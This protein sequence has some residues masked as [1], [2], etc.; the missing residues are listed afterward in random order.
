MP[1]I[2]FRVDVATHI[3]TGHWQRCL[4]LARYLKSQ[5]CSITFFYRKYGEGFEALYNDSSFDYRCIGSSKL[6]ASPATEFEWLGTDEQ[7]DSEDFIAAIGEN[8]YDV[9][10]IDHYAIAQNWQRVVRQYIT[11]IVVVD[12]LAN[13]VHDCD[14]LIDQNYYYQYQSRY[15]SLVPSTC[16]K[17]LGP[18]YC[19]LRAEFYRLR[20]QPNQLSN[21][22]ILINFGGVGNFTLLNK[23]I[24]AINQVKKYQFLVITG[25]ISAKQFEVLS[26]KATNSHVRVIKYTSD[27]ASLMHTSAFAIGASGSTVWERFCLG[28]NAALVE[29]TDN[30]AESLLYLSEQ[31]LV[32][33]LGKAENIQTKNLV[34]F[35]QNLVID[36]PKMFDRK[37]K[38][39]HLVDGLGVQRVANSILEK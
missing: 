39:Q 6:N 27:M 13:R 9:C 32:D 33:N 24:E 14:L 38:I 3:G 28:L 18:N 30:Q 1:N 23:T 16:I 35:L 29:L 25:N 15:D 11:T 21:N 20:M 26:A 2:A 8:D 17:L 4:T 7:T 31:N 36:S 12:D 34:D 19:L 22:Q 10:I 37:I 5:G